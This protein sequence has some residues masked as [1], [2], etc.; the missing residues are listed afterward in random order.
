VRLIG[1]VLAATVA[2]GS[3]ARM[4]PPP[5]GPPD[6]APPRIVA[7]RPESLGSYPDFQGSVEFV[8]DEVISEGSTPSQGFGTGDLEKLVLL[9]P[10][11]G[12]PRV[13]WKRNRLAVA[14]RDGWK[15]N[16]VYRV[17]LLAGV[18]DLRRNRLD[19]TRTVTFTTGAPLPTDTLRGAAVDWPAGR[20]ARGALLEFAL[21]PDSLVYRALAD[22][23]GRF[24]VGPLPRGE[25]LVTAVLDRN[26]NLRRDGREAFDTARVSSGA[27]RDLVLWAFP[28][29][30]VAPRIQSVTLADSQAAV[31][32]FNQALDPYQ[33]PESLTARLRLL[34]DSTPV[35]VHSLLPKPLDDSLRQLARR[36]ADSTRAAADTVVPPPVAPRPAPGPGRPRTP[37][38]DTAA[39]RAILARR[40]LPYDQLVLRPDLAFTPGARYVVEIAGP[41]NLSGVAG[42]SRLGFEVPKP[43]TPAAGPA[44]APAPADSAAPRADTTRVRPKP[45]PRPRLRS[46]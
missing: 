28:H 20:L 10:A 9:S 2:L 24:A 18:T 41:R 21:M 27:A 32:S 7:T 11:S 33:P 36:A 16:R 46:P 35:P 8:F 31:I 39:D 30:T 6:T 5:G 4:G 19:S 26:K 12:V 1:G 37:A 45:R 38:A 3:C 29:D 34:P 43:K 25:Y 23:T 40:R 17:Q 42:Q 22:S 44:P 13:E 14:P 15:R